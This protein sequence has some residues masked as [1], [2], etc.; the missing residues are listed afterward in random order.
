MCTNAVQKNKKFWLHLFNGVCVIPSCC[1][2]GILLRLGVT[3]VTCLLMW[4]YALDYKNR[5]RKTKKKYV[6]NK[7]ANV[8]VCTM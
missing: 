8:F 3:C 6:Q 1:H 2:G 4:G 7:T 5:S